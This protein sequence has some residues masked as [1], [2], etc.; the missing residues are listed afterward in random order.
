MT[1]LGTRG[2]YNYLMSAHSSIRRAC[3]ATAFHDITM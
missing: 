3:A 2:D 1:V